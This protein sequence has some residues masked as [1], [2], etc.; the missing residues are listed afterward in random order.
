MCDRCH[1][2]TTDKH[3]P[4]G[5]DSSVGVTEPMPSM[6]LC[7]KTTEKNTEN[8]GQ[9]VKKKKNLLELRMTQQTFK[10]KTNAEKYLSEMNTGL[11]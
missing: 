3:D 8:Q 6:L 7:C 1:L 4:A 2:Q 11:S 9:G 5:S 10:R